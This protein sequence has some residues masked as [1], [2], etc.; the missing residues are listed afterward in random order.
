[1]LLEHTYQVARV[2]S[3]AAFLVYGLS[4]LVSDGMVAEFERFGLGRF[5]RLTGALE[6]LGAVGLLV[7]YLVPPL[8]IAASGG[9]T[10]LMVLGVITRIRVRDSVVAM[11][12]AIVLLLVNL[13]VFVY[14]LRASAS[15]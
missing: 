12:P 10:L 14:A 4:C 6:V 5:R 8:V 7:G 1:M 3:A 15:P 9:L 11:L 2:L 13:Y